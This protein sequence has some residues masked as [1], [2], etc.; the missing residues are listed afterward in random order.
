[1]M[2]TLRS[3]VVRLWRPR[4]MIG[5]LGLTAAAAVLINMVMFQL[6]GEGGS[7]PP[8]GPGVAF[9]DAAT[10]ASNE[11]LI[12]GLS[13]AASMFGVI[14]LAFWATATASDTSS[15]LIRL[16]VAAQP[17]RWRLIAGKTLA[18]TLLTAL[19]TTVAT[20]VN[21]AAANALAPLA[22]LSTDAW[23]TDLAQVAGEAWLN[24]FATLVVWGV[25]GLALAVL[26][27][28]AAAA[29]SIGVGYV[30][31]VE[32]VITAAASDLAEW[33]PGST[34][35]ALAAGGNAVIDYGTAAALALGYVVV[36]LGLAS[37][38]LTR[39]DITD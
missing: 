16:L 7:T 9:P 32:S 29:V 23:G 24:T 26:T 8:A 38:V 11:G 19:V 27:R 30:L 25:I 10:L 36:G 28:S 21:I 14:T 2:N 20:A 22:D 4:L 1:M 39:R 35:S 34:L 17:H 3:E 12:V 37:V 15:G 13:A 5:W 31:V 18:L 33:L 6:V